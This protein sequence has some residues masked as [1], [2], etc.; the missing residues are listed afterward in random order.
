MI[1]ALLL[2]L[3]AA[4]SAD[5]AT[6]APDPT[7]AASLKLDHWPS[8]GWDLRQS[9]R[10]A[11]LV[12]PGDP[13]Q[14]GFSIADLSPL[15]QI[16]RV[17][18][19]RGPDA[20]ILHIALSCRCE[21]VVTPVGAEALL[22]DIVPPAAPMSRAA[23]G[24]RSAAPKWA[25]LATPR[26][27]QTAEDIELPAD[28]PVL[29]AR[30]HLAEQLEHAAAT[31]LIALQTPIDERSTAAVTDAAQGQAERAETPRPV[32]AAA[33][34]GP[35]APRSQSESACAPVDPSLFPPVLRG[36]AFLRAL[37]EAR[38]RLVGEF[39]RTVKSSARELAALYLSQGWAEE[40]F[41]TLSAF[42]PG[43]PGSAPLANLAALLADPDARRE[44]HDPACETVEGLWHAVARAQRD[45]AGPF[46]IRSEDL[47]RELEQW[48]PALRHR[49][50]LVLG[51]A[52]RQRGLLD[53]AH[54]YAIMARR[55]APEA[56]ADPDVELLLARI[57]RDRGEG[58]AARTAFQA[59]V[60]RGGPI[61]DAA[62]IDLAEMLLSQ[63]G[64]APDGAPHLR[65]ALGAAARLGRATATGARAFTA[66]IRLAARALGSEAA[67]QG[68]IA[69]HRAGLIDGTDYAAEVEAMTRGS[70]ETET[71]LALLYHSEPTR[72]AGALDEP[73]FRIAL[74]RSY[75][76]LGATPLAE[77]VLRRGDREDPTVSIALAR[78][79]LL[80]GDIQAARRYAE[81]LPGGA[82]PALLAEIALLDG[83]DRDASDLIGDDAVPNRLRAGLAGQVGA[84][85]R[86]VGFL[87]EMETPN[88]A[89]I[90]LRR[91]D[92]E[93]RTAPASPPL[94]P[95]PDPGEIAAFLQRID[96]EAALIESVLNDG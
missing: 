13:P 73:G 52:A 66:E 93:A 64:T 76:T 2:I 26:P 33:S 91:R 63:D 46:T 32:I 1:R 94:S 24:P 89:A 36:E 4:V 37:A 5:A 95:D 75:A 29:H 62:A 96:S 49:A 53:P 6:L 78:S 15:P 28:D 48:P 81:R 71:P 54:R 3:F 82:A 31:G 83:T 90:A 58:E 61:G 25:P 72:F 70:A 12:F 9:G 21:V 60:E 27:T 10:V 43:D 42:A 11:S 39:D 77:E 88:D 40:A 18:E 56:A 80:Q 74:A 44:P 23:A 50:A 85:D 22:I 34:P 69:G 16:Q 30:K 7:R 45:V 92:A 79:Y 20:W 38:G 19:E 35:S 14:A 65:L 51:E 8:R 68:L 84:W 41:A 47:D 87:T 55:S 57:A 59:L 17:I 86:A 67:L